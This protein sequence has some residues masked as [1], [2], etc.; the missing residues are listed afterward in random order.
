MAVAQFFAFADSTKI[1]EDDGDSQQPDI[2][3]HFIA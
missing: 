1:L 2:I 3:D